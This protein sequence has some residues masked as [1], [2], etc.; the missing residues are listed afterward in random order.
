MYSCAH[1]RERGTCDNSLRRPVPVVDGVV[2]DWISDR[3]LNEEIVVK[4]L[5][6]VRRRLGER[7]TK[8]ASELPELEKRAKQLGDEIEKIGEAILTSTEPPRRLVQMISEREQEQGALQARI[9]ALKVAPSVFDLEVRRLEKEARARLAD[10]RGL[11][12]R[13]TEQAR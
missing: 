13:N 7:S 1:H 8:T 3:V 11:I 9:N 6:E 10:L 5:R 2:L 12:S 4:C